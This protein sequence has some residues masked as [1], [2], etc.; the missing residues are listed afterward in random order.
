MQANNSGGRAN[1]ETLKKITIISSSQETKN[2]S[3]GTRRQI[4]RVEEG[5]KNTDP[6]GVQGCTYACLR[7]G[8][9]S[10]TI[11]INKDTE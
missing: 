4:N 5:L 9:G 8:G 2:S 10:V 1:A 11:R 3:V 7:E 6:K